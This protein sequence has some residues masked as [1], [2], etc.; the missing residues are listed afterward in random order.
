MSD[1]KKEDSLENSNDSPFVDFSD[2]DEQVKNENKEKKETIKKEVEAEKES[3]K[4][5]ESAAN[6]KLA[7]VLE[8]KE[9][10]KPKQKKTVE[11]TPAPQST[12]VVTESIPEQ[13]KKKDSKIVLE[14]T[15][16]ESS[17]DAETP[18]A[19]ENVEIPSEEEES[20]MNS[21][22]PKSRMHRVVTEG[23]SEETKE[24]IVIDYDNKE[25][26]VAE[27]S[28][29]EKDIKDKEEHR[30]K[31]EEMWEK[32]T[33]FSVCGGEGGIPFAYASDNPNVKALREYDIPIDKI[34]PIANDD[35]NLKK[36]FMEQ[37]I[38]LTNAKDSTVVDHRISR[39]PCLLSGY[40]CEI[41]D[42]SIGELT[43]IIRIIRSTEND[44]VYKFQQELVSLYNHISWTSLKPNGEKLTF[45][46]WL[47]AT[48][49]Q[50]LDMFYW[51]AYDAT[52]PGKGK[53]DIT[54]GNCGSTFSIEKA[55]RA[56]AYLLQNGNDPMLKDTF[57]RD[58]LMGKLPVDEFKKL[59]IYKK[60]NTNFDEKVIK[61]HN[62]RISY[63]CPSLM[64]VLEYLSVFKGTLNEIEDLEALIDPDMDG[65]NI[66]TLFTLIKSITVPVS[67]GKNQ[68]GKTVLSFYKVDTQIDDEDKRLENRKYIVSILKSL[69]E[70]EFS[71]LFVGKE[72]HERKRLVGITTILHNITC[73]NC[74]SNI[75]RIPVD[76]RSNF[77]IKTAAAV[78][79]IEQF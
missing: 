36:N 42:Y 72:L 4:T 30:K 12:P 40:Y 41:T 75:A 57:I 13:P 79:Q 53:Y 31:L 43:S 2:L 46:E 34:K 24:D 66:L 49:F 78:D 21:I 33:G 1:E 32:R 5:V 63:G 68:D 7:E 44:F 27:D 50:D 15:S 39:F 69:P 56:L 29:T 9:A 6:D 11:E 47:K 73:P 8:E 19:D 61:P 23:E 71:D 54:C 3:A 59:L 58:V 76:M 14:S 70:K 26:I 17:I 52:Y 77:F 55:N 22:D 62:I 20:L 65:H 10:P 60:A 16:E 45:E 18:I 64:D 74:N 67:R 25:K 35:E 51:G 38:T 37:Y 48:K 28:L